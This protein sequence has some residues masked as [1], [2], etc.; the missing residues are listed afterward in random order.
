M[1]V[2]ANLR[3]RFLSHGQLNTKPISTH[4]PCSFGVPC[5]S[6]S[7]TWL[8]FYSLQYLAPSKASM[9]MRDQETF[10]LAVI[11]NNDIISAW[12]ELMLTQITQHNHPVVVSG[13]FWLCSR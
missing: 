11:E 12:N 6:E 2:P 8:Y 5:A 3:D 4:L 7:F 13:H 9:P 1:F 10:E